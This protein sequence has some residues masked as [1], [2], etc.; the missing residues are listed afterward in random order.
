MEY[1][2]FSAVIIVLLFLVYLKA[3]LKREKHEDCSDE[4]QIFEADLEP[5]NQDNQ[6]AAVLENPVE[7]E[8]SVSDVETPVSEEEK[9]QELSVAEELR[10]QRWTT[11]SGNWAMPEVELK[12][13]I[14]LL[15]EDEVDFL[16][17][18]YQQRCSVLFEE[19][20]SRNNSWINEP[21]KKIIGL[22]ISLPLK[23]KKAFKNKR[24]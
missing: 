7:T 12:K 18:Q 17:S 14:N 9:K 1:V 20:N 11:L 2:V 15:S 13:L 19:V 23:A 5:E 22:R 21:A 6:H 16:I 3:V 4:S 24:K 8:T 10:W